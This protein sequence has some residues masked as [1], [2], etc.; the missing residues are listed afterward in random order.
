MSALQVLSVVK[1]AY[2]STKISDLHTVTNPPMKKI[3]CLSE[4]S[5]SVILDKVLLLLSQLV[6]Y[7]A[8]HVTKVTIFQL[9][10]MFMMFEFVS[11]RICIYSANGWCICHSFFFSNQKC[12]L[13]SFS[14]CRVRCGNNLNAYS[15]ISYRG[16]SQNFKSW[17]CLHLFVV[18]LPEVHF[19]KGI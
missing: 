18:F 16:C 6:P 5:N 10:Y 17:I 12:R 14:L 15:L 4:P 13:H 8:K 1:L 11:L 2:T 19:L 9:A 7:H 3:Q